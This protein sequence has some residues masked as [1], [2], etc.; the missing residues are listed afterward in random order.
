[1][2]K[3][4]QDRV[5]TAIVG[6]YPKPRSIY[7][8]KWDDLID[9][10]GEKFFD[11]ETKIGKIA[12][13]KRLDQAAL[14]AVRDQNKAGTDIV[15]DGEERRGHF[16]L[17]ILRGLEGFDFK[18]MQKVVIRDVLERPVPLCTGSIRYKGPILVKEFLFT[19]RYAQRIP[20]IGLPGP[21]TVVDTSASGYYGKNLEKMAFDY[22][23]AIRHEV[24][25]LIEA[26]CRVI[27]FDDPALLRNPE[28]AKGWGI[29]SLQECFKGLENKATYIVHICRGYPNK[30][31][32]RK[33][34][35]YKAKAEYYKDVLRWFSQSAID[36]VSIEGQQS[37]LD[38]SVL[39]AI[40]K[41]SIMLGVVDVGVNK[42]ESVASLVARGRQAL[43][44]LPKEQLILAPDCGLVELT[45]KAAFG[46]LRNMTQAAEIL[47]S[48]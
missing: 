27:Q 38:L 9:S 1:M 13:K 45:R 21:S 39:P 37:K 17:H 6:S 30:P 28:R 43:K 8:G 19:A 12:F 34:I 36:V 29:K 46:K 4:D 3:M 24:K 44:Y 14:Q 32:E 26:G 31:L 20:K 48:V 42:V 5:L 10:M 33:G 11:L 35:A 25:A 40:G 7:P 41:K 22:A 15:T 23:R 16:V 2:A 18:K 47:N